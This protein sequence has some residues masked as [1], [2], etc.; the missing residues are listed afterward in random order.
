VRPTRAP[1]TAVVDIISENITYTQLHVIIG[2]V[3]TRNISN[4]HFIVNATSDVTI[5]GVGGSSL[6]TIQPNHNTTLTIRY[7]NATVDIIDLRAFSSIHSFNQLLA[8]VTTLFIKSRILFTN[9]Q[10]TTTSSEM[11]KLK[12]GSGQL[13]YIY[14][15]TISDLKE[16]NFIFS[17][18]QIEVE[19]IGKMKQSY[20]A[21]I[22]GLS[23]AGV[24][25]YY[26]LY[27]ILHHKFKNIFT[28][29]ITQI[30]T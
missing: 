24:F 27:I 6:F 20:G 16:N 12:L 1:S 5:V 18:T 19:P 22:I 25:L 13:I 17:H 23:F 9:Q 28:L 26:L 15:T 21:L 2:G 29:K 10:Q 30:I 7:F 14:N 3:Y 4:L 8:V 11:L